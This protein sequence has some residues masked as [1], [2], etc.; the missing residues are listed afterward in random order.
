[1]KIQ[2]T[3]IWLILVIYTVANLLI[4]YLYSKGKRNS[5]EFFL[6]SNRTVKPNIGAF[7]IAST[8]IWA[9]ALFIS[10][11]KAYTQGI[12]GFFW[13]FVPNVLTLIIFGFF[14]QKLRNMKP[15]G[16]SF[17]DYMREKQSNRIHNLYLVES[18]GLQ[19][20][21]FSVQL[22]AGAA[23][24]YKLSGI[25]FLLLT[26]VLS[27]IPLIY[28]YWKGIWASIVTD[29]WQMIWILVALIIVIPI[30]FSNIS[31]NSVIDG[32]G[33]V[34]GKYND[35]FSNESFNVLL[36]FGIPT[37][38]GLL[39]GPFGD[40]MFWQRTFSIKKDSVRSS[41]IKGALIFAI[42]PLSLSLLGFSLAGLGIEIKDTQ[43]TNVENI[44]RFTPYWCIFPFV[45][46]I[47]SGLVSTVSSIT[48]ATSSIAGHDF[49]KRLENR[50]NIVISA[51]RTLYISRIAMIAVMVIAIFIANLP[52]IKI[53][54]LFL[55]Y[56]TLRASVLL[57]TIYAIKD[58]RMSEKGLFN[59][60]L[61]SFLVGLPVFSIG[62]LYG[63]P[64][65]II[66]GSLISL[67]GSG[68]L[69]L[70]GKK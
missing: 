45:F 11:E 39:S 61:V 4:T 47:L 26:V 3:D 62:N 20:L 5:K 49:I 43:L 37:T 59:G 24:L 50:N 38:I 21:S 19:I 66:T 46:M 12:I 44:I 63:L 6:V 41:F 42:V 2:T 67:L 23:I 56:G 18:L 25:N 53:L 65:I 28:T 16:W 35:F 58:I 1:M 55:F 29:F 69:C 64:W 17:S 70:M 10:A 8:W 33:G 60:I 57:P 36:S 14:S 27:I 32:L 68:T 40:Q 9:P 52:G 15:D 51:K 34:S 7:S 13:F 54:Y 31:F 30:V 48:C 22:L